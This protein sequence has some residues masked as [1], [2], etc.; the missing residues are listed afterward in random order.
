MF[1]PST[2]H[3]FPPI[4]TLT[5][6]ADE[7][8]DPYEDDYNVTLLISRLP[9]IIVHHRFVM[10]QRDTLVACSLNSRI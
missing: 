4:E 10:C 9:V 2:P 5:V 3:L 6:V 1:P 8:K 7:E